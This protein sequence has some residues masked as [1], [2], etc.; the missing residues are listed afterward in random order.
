[1]FAFIRKTANALGAAQ[2]GSAELQ[3][4]ITKVTPLVVRI[5]QE[6]T[7]GGDST[8]REPGFQRHRYYT[9][10]GWRGLYSNQTE[11]ALV[12]IDTDDG[13]SG[14]GEGQSP[15]GPEVTGEIIGGIL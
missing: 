4:K 6:D 5:P 7:F 11:T 13:I 1:M 10:K 15:I 2:F 14:I 9:Q 12:K 8:A 3:M